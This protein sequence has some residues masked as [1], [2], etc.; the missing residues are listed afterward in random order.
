MGY[1]KLKP[2]EQL[3]I[4]QCLQIKLEDVKDFITFNTKSG[5]LTDID[6]EHIFDSI[7]EGYV[8]GEVNDWDWNGGRKN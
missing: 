8:E 1:W 6:E 2:S 4:H 3:D 5:K 7:R